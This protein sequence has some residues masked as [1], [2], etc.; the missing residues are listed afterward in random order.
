MKP[1]APVT[2][3][4]VIAVPPTLHASRNDPQDPRPASHT[5]SVRRYVNSV[6]TGSPSGWGPSQTGPHPVGGCGI[7]GVRVRLAQPVGPV[8]P[9]AQG[10]L[11]RHRGIADADAPPPR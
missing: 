6:R 7:F 3:I 2:S 1:A 5:R 11:G 10:F 4:R 9:S 8:L